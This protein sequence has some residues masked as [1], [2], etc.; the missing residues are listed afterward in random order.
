MMKSFNLNIITPEKTVYEG[1]VVS[2]MVPAALGYLG[3]LVNHAPLA[4]N[5]HKGKISIKKESGEKLTLNL[6]EKGF[7]E[8]LKNKVTLIISGGI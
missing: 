4:A 8:V 1:R 3:V 2:L 7:I 5:L 6:E